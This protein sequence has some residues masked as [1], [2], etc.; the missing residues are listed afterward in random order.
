MSE[1]THDSLNLSVRKYEMRNTMNRNYAEDTFKKVS[2]RNTAVPSVV[3]STVMASCTQCKNF[4]L[5]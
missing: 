1:I 5:V 3:V 2:L 4:S